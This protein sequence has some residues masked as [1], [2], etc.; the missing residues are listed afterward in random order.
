MI[1]RNFLKMATAFAGL[2]GTQSLF[3]QK[4]DKPLRGPSKNQT[5]ALW[6]D[7]SKNNGSNPDKRPRMEVY[8]PDFLF[9]PDKKL[10]A[11]LICPGGGYYIHA[12]H[13]G[14]A[15][16]RLFAV[17]GFV[18][19]VLTYRVN[20]DRHPGPYSD[21]CRAMRLLR[22]QAESYNIDPQKIAIM[23]FSAGGHLASTVA[24]QP[25][26]YFE[27][28]DD[29]AGTVSAR[30]DRVILGY[31]VISF[32]RYAHVGSMK[33]LLGENPDPALVQQLSNEKQVTEKTPPAFLFHLADDKVVPVQNSL[34]FAAACAEH[35]V[36]FELH[37]FPQGGHGVGMGLAYGEVG[38]W[39]DLLMGWMADWTA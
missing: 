28:E 15:F 37:V 23:G 29:L 3:A 6:Q 26:L 30:P 38:K 2:I 16:A 34:D 11:V 32:T 14:Q 25:E 7:G 22:A 35:Q 36:P 33:A 8:F 10:P 5:V 1:R 39:T 27:P 13:E 12:P 4:K 9:D 17:H 19:A 24:T 21:A 20:P 31:P 18:A